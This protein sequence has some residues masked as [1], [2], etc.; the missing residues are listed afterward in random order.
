MSGRLPCASVE[1]CN[2]IVL[3]QTAPFG[4]KPDCLL[5]DLLPEGGNVYVTTV[6]K[7][8]LDECASPVATPWQ[9]EAFLHSPIAQYRK[10]TRAETWAAAVDV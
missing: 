1:H 3:L 4:V 9:D 7:P 5:S 10:Q 2:H 8:I 6:G